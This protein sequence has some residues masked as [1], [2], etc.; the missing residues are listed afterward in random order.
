M[1]LPISTH[2][3]ATPGIPLTPSSLNY[4]SIKRFSAVEQQDL[5]FDLPKRLRISLRPMTPDNV[6]T[7]RITDASGT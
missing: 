6:R 2:F 4:G 3:T 1:F 7:L 5:T